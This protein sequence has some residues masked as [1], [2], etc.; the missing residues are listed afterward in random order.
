[1]MKLGDLVHKILHPFVAGT[2][3]EHC[4]TCEERRVK[5]NGYSDGF[6]RWLAKISCPCYYRSLLKRK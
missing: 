1:M 2:K 5:W 3:L 6:V 4:N